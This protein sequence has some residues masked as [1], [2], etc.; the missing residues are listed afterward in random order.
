[1]AGGAGRYDLVSHLRRVTQSPQIEV[2]GPRPWI[3][4]ATR[5]HIKPVCRTYT[6][7]TAAPYSGTNR[8][9]PC[10]SAH[11]SGLAVA[12]VMVWTLFTRLL[13]GDWP[14]Q[15]GALD[16]STPG[17][18]TTQI[19]LT[20]GRRTVN[21]PVDMTVIAGRDAAY[22]RQRNAELARFANG[23]PAS[24]PWRPSPTPGPYRVWWTVS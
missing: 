7:R 11:P 13:R 19:V 18:D 8:T 23:S 16:E 4:F 2:S 9:A 21:S 17:K 1:M 5:A 24:T 22:R 20:H 3:E 10:R 12:G 15:V 14:W 6:D